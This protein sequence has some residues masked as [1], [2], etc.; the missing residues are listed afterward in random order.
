MRCRKHLGALAAAGSVIVFIGLANGGGSA[1]REPNLGPLQE[2]QSSQDLSLPLQA[3]EADER[4]WRVLYAARRAL[5]QQCAT[6]FGVRSTEPELVETQGSL[7]I[8][9]R[10]G[11]VDEVRVRRF[12]Y[13]E[14][15]HAD[16]KRTEVVWRP[17]VS[18]QVV[19]TGQDPNGGSAGRTVQAGSGRAL[20]Q[21]GCIGEATRLL[22]SRTPHNATLVEALQATSFRKAE[23]DSR[24]Q[25]AWADWAACMRERGLSYSSPWQPND[26]DW[27]GAPSGAEQTTALADLE[28]RRETRLLDVWLTVEAAY[29][30][31][32]INAERENLEAWRDGHE[33]RVERARQILSQVAQDS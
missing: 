16:A 10:Y 23:G 3:W 19:M 20:P 1:A 31:R 9:R 33:E 15:Q 13:A 5:A 27:S 14:P 4:D 24:V 28:C 21:G 26:R 2:V 25:G 29:Q 7:S 8:S 11:I 6:R 22:S 17:S 32:L 18:E 12:G 30:E